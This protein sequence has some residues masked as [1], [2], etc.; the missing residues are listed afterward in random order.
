MKTDFL[1]CSIYVSLL[2]NKSD[3]SNVRT[4]LVSRG[5]GH[6]DEHIKHKLITLTQ[7]EL[8]ACLFFFSQ[9]K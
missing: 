4:S 7:G 9:A 3:F 1:H 5:E 6:L 2:E 8:L